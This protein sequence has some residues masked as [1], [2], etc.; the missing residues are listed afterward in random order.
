MNVDSTIRL[1]FVSFNRQDYSRS[2]VLLNG[3][4]ENCSPKFIQMPN[5]FFYAYSYAIRNRKIF[6]EDR[7]V[8]IVMSPSNK[9]TTILKMATKNPIISQTPYATTH[10]LKKNSN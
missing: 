9:L 2:S 10:L 5:R 4:Y 8:T 1:N 3:K 6:N 7:S